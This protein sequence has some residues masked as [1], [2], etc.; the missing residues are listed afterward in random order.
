MS[1]ESHHASGASCSRVMRMGRCAPF[2]A[3]RSRA[4][5]PRRPPYS[6]ARVWRNCCGPRA[7]SSSGRMLT[8]II[9]EFW[10]GSK[11]VHLRWRITSATS[12]QRPNKLVPVPHGTTTSRQSL[13]SPTMASLRSPSRIGAY[14]VSGRDLS[15]DSP[16]RSAAPAA[17]AASPSEVPVLRRTSAAEVRNI[18]ARTTDSRVTSKGKPNLRAQHCSEARAPDSR[19]TVWL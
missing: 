14:S 4:G 10:I 17:G 9:S 13:N 11:T 5:A 16:G 3:L 6:C 19:S 8:R 7:C 2:Q 15:G 18:A 1:N 12:K